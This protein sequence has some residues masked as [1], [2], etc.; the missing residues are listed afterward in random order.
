MPSQS[1]VI[2]HKPAAQINQASA[3]SHGGE[4]FFAKQILILRF[5]VDMQGDYVSSRE[6]F[7]KADGPRI[8]ASQNVRDVIKH[9][10]HSQ[11]FGQIRNLRSD[12]SIA[13]DAESEPAHFMRPRRRFVPD[14][15]MPLR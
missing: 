12:L 3:V 2:D 10:P 5:P 7:V 4:F 8:S 9:N 1:L 11:S 13:D 15:A 6:Q 14:S